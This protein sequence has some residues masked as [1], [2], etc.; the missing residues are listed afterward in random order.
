M[1]ADLHIHTTASD[2]KYTP[3]EVVRWARDSGI[4]VMSVT[5]HD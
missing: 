3:K 1:I 4:E 2:G 5:D